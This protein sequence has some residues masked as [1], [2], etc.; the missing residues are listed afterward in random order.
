[1]GYEQDI[2]LMGYEALPQVFF[3]SILAAKGDGNE[4]IAAYHHDAEIAG[5]ATPPNRFNLVW[6]PSRQGNRGRQH[7]TLFSAL[8]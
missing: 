5:L 6:F 7:F 2:A 8:V 3:R 4:A 1:L